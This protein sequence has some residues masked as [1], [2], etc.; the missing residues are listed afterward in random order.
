MDGKI[1]SG[2]FEYFEGI[3]GVGIQDGNSN[4]QGS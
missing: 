2:D 3:A 1:V 4:V